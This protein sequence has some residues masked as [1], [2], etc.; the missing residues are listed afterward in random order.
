M[1]GSILRTPNLSYIGGE[2]LLVLAMMIGAR[3]CYSLLV[4]T[5]PQ[6]TFDMYAYAESGQRETANAIQQRTSV[7]FNE[8]TGLLDELGQGDINP[9]AIRDLP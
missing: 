8:L 9:F 5:N 2:D 1:Q 7:F 4:M 3:G 6:F